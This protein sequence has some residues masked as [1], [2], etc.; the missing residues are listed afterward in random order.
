MYIVGRNTNGYSHYQKQY[1]LSQELKTEPLYCQAIIFLVYKSRKNKSTNLKKYMQKVHHRNIYNS[2]DVASSH[3]LVGHL[4]VF[5]GMPYSGL[6]TFWFG[7]LLFDIELAVVYIFLIL[8]PFSHIICKYVLLS[9][10]IREQ[11]KWKPQLQENNQTDHLD[12][13]LT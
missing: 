10:S 5:F 12:N 7:S 13:S 9:L 3:M 2:Q 11:T 4:Y 6:L 1:E 8:I